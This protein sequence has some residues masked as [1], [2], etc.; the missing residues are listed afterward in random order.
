MYSWEPFLAIG[1]SVPVNLGHLFGS[2]GTRP[3]SLLPDICSLIPYRSDPADPP[4]FHK[5]SASHG[6][7]S[8]ATD[9]L[10]LKLT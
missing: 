8:P 2:W 7:K 9:F 4:L 3:I 10:P 6:S 5:A 1:R